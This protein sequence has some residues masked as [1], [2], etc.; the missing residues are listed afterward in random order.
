MNRRHQIALVL[1]L[2]VLITL[3]VAA[4]GIILQQITSCHQYPNEKVWS[5]EVA[6]LNVTQT[7]DGTVV[8]HGEV[9]VSGSTG[10]PRIDDVVVLFL[11]D[12]NRTLARVPV[13]DFGLNAQFE[14]NL[15][16]QLEAF[17]KRV[18]LETGSVSAGE[19]TKWG[20]VGLLRG[21][22]GRYREY[23]QRTNPTPT[24]CA[25]G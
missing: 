3:G 1:S 24:V 21:P 13:G 14:R 25:N 2:V 19:D 8:F 10:S 17:P 23:V 18:L 16:V 6:A 15:T 22:D 5:L 11:D 12:T 7:E 4:G 9:G 20:I